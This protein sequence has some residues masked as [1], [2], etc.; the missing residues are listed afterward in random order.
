MK[1]LCVLPWLTFDTL[2]DGAIA[3][4]CFIEVKTRFKIKN[5]SILDYQN[6]SYLSDIKSQMLKG[7]EPTACQSCY[8]QEKCGAIS[9]RQKSNKAYLTEDRKKKILNDSFQ[10]FEHL[11]L[12]MS[13]K[14]DMS[15]RSCSAFSSTTWN[16]DLLKIDSNF[17]PINLDLFE[18][19]SVLENDI[20]KLTSNVEHLY[21]SG[22]EPFLDLRTLVILKSFISGKNLEKRSVGIQTNL[23]NGHILRDEFLATL[24]KIP[25]LNILISIDGIG[26][27]G[28]FIRNGLNW[29]NFLE[30]LYQLKK[31]LPKVKIVFTP[32][33]SVYN[34]QHIL[35]L[36]DFLKEN[37][38]LKDATIEM[39]VVRAPMALNP[40]ILPLTYKTETSALYQNYLKKLEGHP[41]QKE[42]KSAIDEIEAFLL[43][44]DN[45]SELINFYAYTKTIDRIRGQDTFD[46][47]PE[48]K[49][50]L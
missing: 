10:Y 13:N 31:S 4:C 24:E 41:D 2:Q 39:G 16:K 50:V 7:H 23:T 30:N 47:F 35:K 42:I 49:F 15:C 36:F 11:H 21:L 29:Q 9:P 46:L 14:C 38:F 22:G 45:N 44:E 20:I 43:S 18:G 34:T 19:N 3:P 40:T 48:L 25:K 37:Q 17:T 33:Y 8:K 12:R 32:T 6:S 27:Q 28:E 1:T 5:K 26:S